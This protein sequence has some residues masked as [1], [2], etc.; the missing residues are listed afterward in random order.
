LRGYTEEQIPAYRYLIFTLEPRLIT[1]KYDR[2]YLFGDFGLIK[3]AP[4]R[5]LDYTFKP[6][7]GFGLVSRSAI[8]QLKVEIGWGDEGFPSEAVFNFGIMG[9]F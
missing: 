3:G 9:S 4:D 7:Y 5:D 8:G 6:G 2:V 1:G